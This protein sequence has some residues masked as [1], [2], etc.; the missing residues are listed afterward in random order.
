[1]HTAYMGFLAHQKAIPT[2]GEP[3]CYWCIRNPEINSRPATRIHGC[4]YRKNSRVVMLQS[5]LERTAVHRWSFVTKNTEP[6]YICKV[7]HDEEELREES[8]TCFD[9]ILDSPNLRMLTKI[10]A[11]QEWF[12]LRKF[13]LTSSISGE[14]TRK[15]LREEKG[16]LS[17]EELQML[18]KI[19]NVLGYHSL[20]ENENLMDPVGMEIFLGKLNKKALQS[21]CKKYIEAGKAWNQ[22]KP[23]LVAKLVSA[24]GDNAVPEGDVLLTINDEG[25]QCAEEAATTP[26]PGAKSMYDVLLKIWFMQP[27]RTR[28]LYLGKVNEDRV[29]KLMLAGFLQKKGIRLL[30]LKD[31]GLI[32][33][34]RV[35]DNM[36]ATSIDGLLTY[37]YYDHGVKMVKAAILEIKTRSGADAKAKLSKIVFDHGS[38]ITCSAEGTIFKRVL[39]NLDY[40]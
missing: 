5:S 31:V 12:L 36:F 15:F 1:M 9:T 10:Q 16:N 22:N 35:G 28:G 20:N 17:R 18:E 40:R 23:E 21:L 24:L 3:C 33:N 29:K 14:L 13:K 39:P 11:S 27:L 6:L 7:K 34:T 19:C 25:Q 8:K 37:E 30:E 26:N 2:K 4:A 32:V 38:F